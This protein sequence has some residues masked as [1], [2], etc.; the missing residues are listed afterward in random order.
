MLTPPSQS[1]IRLSLSNFQELCLNICFLYEKNYSWGF[2]CLQHSR[3]DKDHFSQQTKTFLALIKGI[4]CIDELIITCLLSFS[5]RYMGC[6]WTV[7]IHFVYMPQKMQ[8]FIDGSTISSG[9]SPRPSQRQYIIN[10][11]CEN[12]CKIDLFYYILSIIRSHNLSKF[13][14]PYR[15][16]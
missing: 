16:Y 3:T 7:G 13:I 4:S 6:S 11:F 5:N 8:L 14:S 2:T 10:D 9:D 1:L 15:I 12:L